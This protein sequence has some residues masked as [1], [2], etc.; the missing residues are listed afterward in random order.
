MRRLDVRPLLLGI[1]LAAAFSAWPRPASAQIISSILP[2]ERGPGGASGGGQQAWH[3]MGGYTNWE[4]GFDAAGR[5]LIE[6][7]GGQ[8]DGGRKGFIVAGDFSVR[9]RGDLSV[10]GGAWY[11]KVTNFVVSEPAGASFPYELTISRAY[12]SIYGN[13]FYKVLGVQAGFVPA[14]GDEHILV[15]GAGEASEDYDQT[16]ANVFA[17]T[18]F[19]S[20][21][22]GPRWLATIGAGV[23][24]YGTIPA[25]NRFSRPESPRATAFTTFVNGSVGLGAGLSLDA[26]FWY[27]GEDGNYGPESRIG[28]ASQSR[29]T[30]G[31]GYGR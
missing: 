27:V 7:A 18:R 30:I 9:A 31:I 3:V 21:R 10:G 4:F 26:S 2:V 25:S 13:V 29:F 22:P 23:H 1:A 12:A 24:V 8:V 5:D 6:S 16:D 20:T 15:P 28:N 14:R 17:M 19:G 11:N